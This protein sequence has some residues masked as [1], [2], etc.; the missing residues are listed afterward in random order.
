MSDTVPIAYSQNQ[1]LS[2]NIS[3]GFLIE[4]DSGY[5]NISDKNETIKVSSS[6]PIKNFVTKFVPLDF[7]VKAKNFSN[8]ITIFIADYGGGS[9]ILKADSIVIHQ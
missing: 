9:V 4:N 2:S 7:A 5:V 3:V 1:D 6:L 8:P